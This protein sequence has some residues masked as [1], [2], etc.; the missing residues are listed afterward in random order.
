MRLRDSRSGYP[1]ASVSRCELYTTNRSLPGW[2]SQRKRMFVERL[3][4]AVL[5]WR[6]AAKKLRGES[7]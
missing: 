2:Y 7:V 6:K 5:Y 1:G 3:S 4:A